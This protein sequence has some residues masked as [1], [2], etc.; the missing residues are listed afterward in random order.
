MQRGVSDMELRLI[1]GVRLATGSAGGDNGYGPTDIFR[2][3]V[4]F[5]GGVAIGKANGRRA[6]RG[7]AWAR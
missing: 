3:V 2:E 7:I 1:E 4:R 6:C 5:H